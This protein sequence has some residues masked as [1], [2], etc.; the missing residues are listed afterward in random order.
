MDTDSDGRE[1]VNK[2]SIIYFA[3]YQITKNNVS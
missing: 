1:L 2:C 3:M